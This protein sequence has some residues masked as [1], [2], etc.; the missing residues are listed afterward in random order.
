MLTSDHHRAPDGVPVNRALAVVVAGDRPLERGFAPT[1]SARAFGHGGAGGQIAW[2]DPESGL[3]LGFVTNGFVP[4][5][6]QEA[7]SREIN[8]LAGECLID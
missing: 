4:A 6:D 2:G 3:S 7:R 5:A 1:V 8:R